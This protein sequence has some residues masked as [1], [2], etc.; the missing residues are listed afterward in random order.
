MI[1]LSSGQKDQST[2]QLNVE[3]GPH[4]PS[5]NKKEE[6]SL[7]QEMDLQQVGEED[8]NEDAEHSSLFSD[9][10][11][12][13]IE[14]ARMAGHSFGQS[15]QG[16][17]VVISTARKSDASESVKPSLDNTMKYPNYQPLERK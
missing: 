14:R 9:C 6:P 17:H 16:K 15:E 2:V 5:D 3:Y 1:E 4:E 7:G 13:R 8:N 10:T 12:G 11:A